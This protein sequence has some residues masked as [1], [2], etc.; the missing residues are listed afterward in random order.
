MT[1]RYYSI[2]DENLRC[3]LCP[4]RCLLPEGRIGLCRVRANS[5]GKLS[6]PY[7]GIISSMATDPIEKKPL[8]HFHPGRTIFSVG[9][10][11][12]NLRC[13]FCQNFSISQKTG[14][15]GTFFSP[16]QIVEEALYRHSF[17]IAYTYSEPIVHIEY[18]LETARVARERGLSNVLVSNGTIIR[19]AALDLISSM[20]AANID[21]KS[22]NP[23]YYKREL[24]GDLDTVLNFIRLAYERVHLEITTLVIPGKN[25]SPE[26]IEAI[27]RFLAGLSKDIPLHLSCYYPSY[28]YDIEATDPKSVFALAEIAHRHLRYV[29]PGN[30]GFAETNTVCPACNETLISRRGY[31]VSVRGIENGRCSSCGEEIPVKGVD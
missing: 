22:F 23:S 20:D 14:R 16:L 30:V 25:D 24:K 21:L 29:Y 31:Q 2:E 9:F 26:E 13:P 3:T 7:Y 5:G 28:T 4:H 10:F 27:A 1:G 15:G 17:G 8:Y 12:C 11:G 6:L 19:E 18:V